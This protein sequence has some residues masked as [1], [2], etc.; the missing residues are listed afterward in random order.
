VGKE[1]PVNDLSL[2]SSH[3]EGAVLAYSL[4]KW[5]LMGSKRIWME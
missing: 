3:G 1:N 4:H 2:P 5:L